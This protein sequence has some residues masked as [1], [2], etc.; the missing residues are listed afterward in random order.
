[1]RTRMHL[2]LEAVMGKLLTKEYL[3]TSQMFADGLTKVLNGTDFD[4]FTNRALNG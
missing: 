3:H 1:M 2:V 4:S